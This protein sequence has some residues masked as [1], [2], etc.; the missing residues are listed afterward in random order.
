VIVEN[1][2][3][4]NLLGR[5]RTAVLAI[6]QFV[7]AGSITVKNTSII[8]FA[9]GLN[10]QGAGTII[11]DFNDIFANS[12][13]FSARRRRE[14]HQHR[15]D[16]A[17]PAAVNMRGR[18]PL[19]SNGAGCHPGHRR[20]P[21]GRDKEQIPRRRWGHTNE[22]TTLPSHRH[23]AWPRKAQALWRRLS[24]HFEVGYAVPRLRNEG[25][26]TKSQTARLRGEIRCLRV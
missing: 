19:R 6:I 18:R 10:W 16:I 3:L 9:T 8:R 20:R 21:G 5:R 15:P 24:E 2:T 25:S 22:T 14:R 17:N 1:C 7:P 23:D 11:A 12:A 4:V 26:L 13:G